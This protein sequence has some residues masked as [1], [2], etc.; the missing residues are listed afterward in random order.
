MFYYYLIQ[1]ICLKI[2]EIF[3]KFLSIE[4]TVIKENYFLLHFYILSLS[5]FHIHMLL[6]NWLI[7]LLNLISSYLQTRTLLVPFAYVSMELIYCLFLSPL[8]LNAILLTSSVNTFC[9]LL[10]NL[11]FH[12]NIDLLLSM[13]S[14][15][16]SL[17]LPTSISFFS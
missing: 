1:L 9:F 11:Y 2:L 3:L 6:Q 8:A 17:R 7:I 12:I 13:Y 16:F 10:L 15:W 5:L 4:I 14:L